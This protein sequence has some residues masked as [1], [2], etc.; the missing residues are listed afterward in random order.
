MPFKVI[1]GRQFWYHEKSYATSY[2]WINSNFCTVS[3]GVLLVRFSPSS[4]WVPL[5]GT[6]LC[7]MVLSIFWYLEPFRR[8]AWDGQTDR[9]RN[10]RAHSTCHVSQHCAA[11][12]PSLLRPLRL[13]ACILRWYCRGHHCQWQSSSSSS[14]SSTNFIATQVLNKVQGRWSRPK[15]WMVPDVSYPNSF[16][17]PWVSYPKRF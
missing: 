17:I 2:V 12:N 3:Y 10:R 14:S 11:K 1:Q 9:Q 4:C 8:N 5:F 13:C 15:V 7:G 6:S 16:V